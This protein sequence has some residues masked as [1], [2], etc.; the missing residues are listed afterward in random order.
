MSISRNSLASFIDTLLTPK[1]FDDY[2]PNGLQVEGREDIHKIVTGVTA[3]I[4]MIEAAIDAKADALLVHHGYFWRGEPAIITGTKRKRIQLLLENQINLLAYHLPL[5]AHLELGNNVQLAE[6]LQWQVTPVA[7]KFP[8]PMVRSTVL[9][10]PLSG[11]DLYQHLAQQLQREPMHIAVDKPITTIAWCT[12]AAQ[13]YIY[14][15]IALGADAFISGEISENTTHIAKENNIHYFA[16]GHHATE[17]YGVKAL[18]EYLD[19]HLDINVE[20]I[21]CH[22]PV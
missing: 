18:G 7:K 6:K 21:D 17:R 14:E 22:N 16:A 19:N 1:K 10:N 8:L 15:A 5:D 9:P 12:G 4:E 13:S 2:C 20:F 3:S 11:T